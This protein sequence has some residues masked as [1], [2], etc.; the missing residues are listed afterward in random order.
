[1]ELNKDS[2]SKEEVQKLISDLNKQVGDLTADLVQS[3]DKVK[4]YDS[5]KKKSLANAIKLEMTKAGLSEDF[6]DLVNA[7]DV[8]SA[9][10]KIE[11]L[12]ELNKTIEKDNGY[13]P[14]QHKTDNA[15]I[16]A[17]KKGNIEGMIKSKIRKL[18]E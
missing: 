15:Y 2:Y 8:E 17:E 12:A 18:F 9:Q 5:L 13:K 4:D 11:K 10:K 3:N 1:M 16:D 6:F 14:E 7:D